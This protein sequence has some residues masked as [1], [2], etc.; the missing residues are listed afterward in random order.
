MIDFQSS[1]PVAAVYDRRLCALCNSAAN[2]N[3][4]PKIQHSKL[5]S[6]SPTFRKPGQA[7]PRPPGEGGG[8]A[9]GLIT[10][11]VRLHQLMSTYVKHPSPPLL[12]WRQA[13]SSP[14][15]AQSSW[16]KPSQAVF[17]KKKI[18][19]FSRRDE[20]WCESTQIN[21]SR[22]KYKPDTGQYW[23]KNESTV[24]FISVNSRN[25]RKKTPPSNLHF[26]LRP[27]TGK[28]P[29][30]CRAAAGNTRFT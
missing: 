19:Y 5:P 2:L 16:V 8:V 12:G 17:R 7:C 23:P 25:S 29:F 14:C 30:L 28:L 27:R 24:F 1:A 18:V 3:S 9:N 11:Q 13:E 4:K 21:P 20:A 22:F 6:N 10:G 26:K 15:Q